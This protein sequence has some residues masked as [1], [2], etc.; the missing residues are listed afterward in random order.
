MAGTNA[1]CFPN[2]PCFTPA[3]AI[4]PA[5]TTVNK[6][7][8]TVTSSNGEILARLRATSTDSVAQTLQF[9]RNVSGVDYVIGESQVPAGAGTNGTTPWK[10]VLADINAGNPI[11]LAPGE[12]LKVRSKVTVTTACQVNVLCEGVPL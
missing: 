5:D 1:P 12:V 3:V 8:R 7:L 6:T 11:T 9:T 4:A 10:D 2:V